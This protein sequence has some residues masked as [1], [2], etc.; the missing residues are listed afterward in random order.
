MNFLTD[1]QKQILAVLA[2]SPAG[3]TI[4]ELEER[5][6]VSRRTIYREFE[7]FRSALAQEGLEI[8]NEKKKYSLQGD[9]PALKKLNVSVQKVQ[10]QMTMTV[11]ERENAI[12]ASLL[13]AN[14][15]CKIIQLALDLN[16]SEATIQ[17]DL[18][19]VEK[20]LAEYKISLIRKKGV[21]ISVASPES[22]RRQVLIGI[23]LSEINDYD[24]F[25]YLHHEQ[26]DPNYFLRLLN[27]DTLV[28]VKECLDKSVFSNIKLDSDYQIIEVILA[29][30][31]SIMRIDEGY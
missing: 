25:R 28:D 16:V 13:L 4:K 8:S 3:L 18:D 31:V 6:G 5:V 20:S 10:G 11:A 2:A 30:T 14:E 19:V 12:A 24:F 23:L 17:N 21:G 1:R 22:E 9:Q 7:N 15:P 27:R 29:F 26:D